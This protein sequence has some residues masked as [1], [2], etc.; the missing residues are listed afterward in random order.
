MIVRRA[1]TGF[2]ST[3][4][5]LSISVSSLPAQNIVPNPGFT[6]SGGL[7]LPL[8]T[9]VVVAPDGVPDSWRAFAVDGDIDLEIV[10]LAADELFPGSPETNAVR[11]RV[12]AFGA[13]QGFDDDN[14]R[15][16]IVPGIDYHAEFWVKSGNADESDQAFNFGFPLFAGVYLGRE[17]GGSTGNVA[18]SDWQPFVA[19]TFQ[20]AEAI[21][22]HISWRCLDDGGENAILIAQPLV[23]QEGDQVVPPTGLRCIRNGADVELTWQNNS[24]YDSLSVLRNTE[25]IAEL[26]TDATSYLDE[27]IPEGTHIYQ[28]IAT[29]PGLEEGPSCEV[30]YVVLEVGTGVSVDLGDIDTEDG[31]VNSQRHDGTDGENEFVIC[32]LD[33][34][35]REARS[36]WG[37]EDPTPDAPDGFFYFN[38]TDPDMKAQETFALTATVYDDELLVGTALSLQYTNKQ[39]TG[40]VD[41][42]N[43]FF[44]LENPPTRF[45]EG[46]GEWVELT[47]KI[48]GA[49]FRSFQQ[50]S[51]DFRL[52]V[53]P[54][55]RICIDRVDLVFLPFVTDL[56][57]QKVSGGV[58]LTWQNGALYDELKIL[59]DGTEI[60]ELTGDA[61]SYLDGDVDEGT[62]V[63]D[64]VAVVGNAE[65]PTSCE[66]TVFFVDPG[67]TVSVDLGDPDLEDGLA[68]SHRGSPGDGE[69]EPV[70]CG[71]DAD[72]RDARSNW[73]ALDPTPGL[74]DEPDGF[75]YFNVTDP[76]MKAQTEFRLEATVYDDPALA[77][78]SLYLQYTNRDS[79][80]P[81]D[82]ANTFFPQEEPEAN[83]LE[84]TDTWVTLEWTIA[85]AGFRS[86]QQGDSD[87]R[88]G[89]TAGARVCIDR[90]ELTYGPTD[91][92]FHR[93]DADGSGTVDLTDGIYKLSFLFLGGPAPACFDAADADDSGDLN[94]TGAIY[95]L[96]WLFTGGTEPPAPGPTGMPCGPDPTPDDFV[97][98]DCVYTHCGE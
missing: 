4:V 26:A 38:V 54:G 65:I 88:L 23:E 90:M 83:I 49:G 8:G 51:S 58:E 5:L 19:P 84:G 21:E 63:Y 50:Q 27:G 68:N 3:F 34:D 98:A 10:P 1:I 44:P 31:M 40:P 64:V 9:G 77:G 55:V 43:T 22:G 2:F 74:L 61:T 75:F 28:V 11:L 85:D 78:V 73:G 79:S 41:I 39:S 57:C 96:S 71:L 20:D 29:A 46:T 30:R 37:N 12:N 94:I 60:T 6:G 67:T 82:I 59:R 56:S 92:I 70:T 80:G 7:N 52:G 45:L 32:G 89:V 33:P 47:W 76:A 72:L 95:I 97:N 25:L 13:D 81:T 24:E 16:P 18:T 62:H 15:F 91:P 35:I 14:G 36:N 48:S 66:I 69:N 53:T 86:F 42:P 87:F 17:P 93:G